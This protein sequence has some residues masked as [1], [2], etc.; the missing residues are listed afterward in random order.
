M[1]TTW[2][3]H[4]TPVVANREKMDRMQIT[5][6]QLDP[7]C[8]SGCDGLWIESAWE[9]TLQTFTLTTLQCYLARTIY[10][11]C[12]ASTAHNI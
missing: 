9:V 11:Y 8:I 7:P 4:H 3:L 5:M 10:V 12:S 1:K 2:K 6:A